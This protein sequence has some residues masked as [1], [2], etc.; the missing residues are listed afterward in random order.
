MADWEQ[1]LV[2]RRIRS[3][4]VSGT[5]PLSGSEG[6]M[7][8]GSERTPWVSY[9]RVS[10]GEQADRELSLPAQRHAVAAYAAQHGAAIDHEYLEAG[11]SGVDPHRATHARVVKSRLRRAGVR[12]LS[13]SQELSSH[14][15]GQLAV[16][17]DR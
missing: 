11:A 6:A 12:V 17:F 10:T 3:L 5:A 16:R 9:L 15:R 7:S 13:V 8:T 2:I 14:L 1:Q 4:V